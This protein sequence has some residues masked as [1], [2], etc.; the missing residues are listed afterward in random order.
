MSQRGSL[1]PTHIQ[2]DIH[3]LVARVSTKGSNTESVV[4]PCL[5]NDVA[6]VEPPI[7]LYVPRQD[8]IELVAL[9]KTYDG[10]ST[11]HNVAYADDVVRVSVEQ[12]I[13]GD[14]EVPFPT[15][16]IKCVRQ[17]LHTFIAWPTPLH[18]GSSPT[19]DTEAVEAVN[20]VVVDDPLHELIKSLVDIYEKPVE[21][22]WDATKFGI[23][24]ATASLFVTCADVNEIISGVQC[25]NIAILQ[26]AFKTLET[27]SEGKF[28]HN[29]L[30]W[31]EVKG[32]VQSGAYECGYYV[33]HWMWNIIVGQLKTNWMLVNF[34]F[35][36]CLHFLALR[37]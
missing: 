8:S 2:P 22:V 37:N 26:F 33:M 25:L 34:V 21:L 16:E 20:D 11:I 10:G 24:N 14:A 19:K 3:G 32:H 27:K 23:P 35:I 15:S 9:G 4:N 28:G 30:R 6:P 13:D 7:G 1:I 36:C 29:T 31:I 18:E 12:V 17:A 5:P